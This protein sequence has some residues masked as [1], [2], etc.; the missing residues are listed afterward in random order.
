MMFR[1]AFGVPGFITDPVF[2]TARNA[3]IHFHC[4]SVTKLDGPKG[5]RMP[6]TMR[7]QTD[8]GRGVALQVDN[9]LGQEVTCAKFVNLADMAY[10][11]G[12]II[13]ISSKPA[14]SAEPSS[15]PRSKTP[16]RCS[17]TGVPAS[18]TATS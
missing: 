16:A 9:R 6:F 14:R 11:T 18:S 15:S 13:E 7:T 17:S 10:S 1:Y 8:S 2:D 4:T 12:K 3:L 5:E